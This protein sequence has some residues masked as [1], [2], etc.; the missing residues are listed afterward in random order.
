MYAFN[1]LT[2]EKKWS[3]DCLSYMQWPPAISSSGTVYIASGD[4]NVRFLDGQSGVVLN[5]VI[6]SNGAISIGADGTLFLMNG[7]N[8]YV[9]AISC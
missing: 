3:T 2:G 5:T 4:G 8:G 1:G 9:Y 7:N 6:E